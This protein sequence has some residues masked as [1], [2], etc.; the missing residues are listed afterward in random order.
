MRLF[1]HSISFASSPRGRNLYGGGRAFASEEMSGAFESRISGS[2]SPVWV[3]HSR[4]S[5]ESPAAWNVRASTPSTPSAASRALSSPAA[6]SVN[7][8]ARIWFASNAPLAT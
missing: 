8:T 2:G 7:V 3:C 1:A 6:F 5:C 4:P